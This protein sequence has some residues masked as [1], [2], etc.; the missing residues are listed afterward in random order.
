M[1]QRFYENV[2]V[3]HKVCAL[4]RGGVVQLKAYWFVWVEGGGGLAGSVH[5]L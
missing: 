5:T 4:G 1:H 2:G 3:T